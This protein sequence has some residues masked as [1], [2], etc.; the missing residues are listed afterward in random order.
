MEKKSP[1][2][3]A[4]KGATHA[5]WRKR[6]FT[7]ML[8]LFNLADCSFMGAP[9][10]RTFHPSAIG[11]VERRGSSANGFKQ[12]WLVTVIEDTLRADGLCNEKG[13]FRT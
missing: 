7:L 8:R 6:Y 10:N 9:R 5:S 3:T 12:L 2:A 13:E 4:F 1:L 11:A